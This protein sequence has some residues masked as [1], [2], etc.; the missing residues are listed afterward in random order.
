MD[1]MRNEYMCPCIWKEAM[2]EAKEVM[3]LLGK[4]GSWLLR[5]I[6][7]LQKHFLFPSLGKGGPCGAETA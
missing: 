5:L 2:L 7:L 3:E 4:D 1:G 6:S